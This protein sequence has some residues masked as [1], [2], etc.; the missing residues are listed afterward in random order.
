MDVVVFVGVGSPGKA[1]ALCRG[2][3]E[4]VDR[5]GIV[6][7]VAELV[8][9]QQ[10]RGTGVRPCRP[11]RGGGVPGRGRNPP[12]PRSVSSWLSLFQSLGANQCS[13]GEIRGTELNKACRHTRFRPSAVGGASAGCVTGHDVDTLS[14]GGWPLPRLPDAPPTQGRCRVVH[15][16]LLQRRSVVSKPSR[17]PRACRAESGCTAAK[18]M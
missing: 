14:V 1:G 6:G 17:P 9:A 8:A 16:S 3:L 10:A 18:A 13:H 12:E 5:L 4:D 15:G 2:G 7:G 11:P